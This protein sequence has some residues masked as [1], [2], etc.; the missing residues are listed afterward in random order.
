MQVLDQLRRH[1]LVVAGVA[2][3]LVGT[4]LGLARPIHAAAP[5]A[6]ELGAWADFGPGVVS[7]YDEA[8]FARVRA[9]RLL[10]APPAAKRGGGSDQWRLAGIIVDPSPLALVYGA[11]KGKALRLKVGDALPDGGKL[12]EITARSIR[13]ARAGCQ[14]ERA[15]YSAS[16]L[17][18]AGDCPPG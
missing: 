14:F 6:A 3:L 5:D 11:E 18:V 8:R 9:A 16:D 15:L 4:A 12:T 10:A 1:P 7:R 17:P 2:G 13:F